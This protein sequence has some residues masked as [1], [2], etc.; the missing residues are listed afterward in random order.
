MLRKLFIASLAATMGLFANAGSKGWNALKSDITFIICNDNGR[1]GYYDQ[2]PIAVTMGE[3]AETVDPESVIALGDVFHYQGVE[4]VNDPLWLSNYESVYTH[5]ELM[6]EWLPIL[7]NH[8]YR[9]NTKAVLD[10]SQI[11]RRWCMPSKY[12]SRSFKDKHTSVKVILLDTAPLIDKYRMDVEDYPDAGKEDMEAQLRWLDNE[13]A[14]ATEEWIVV[15]GHHPIYA[16]TDKNESERSDM[17]DRVDKIL[18][19]HRVDMYICGHIHNFQHIRQSD[20]GID[21]IVNSSASQSRENVNPIDGTVYI[22]G[23]SGFSVLGASADKLT[24]SML[25][26]CGEILHQVVRSK[27]Q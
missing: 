7:G 4:S 25:D 24:L 10:Y 2:K 9:G 26:K 23:K 8:E 20:S 13:L 18:R 17:Q 12:Y 11:S 16:D 22:S 15:V 6:V 1:N 5:P 21:Y 19:K 27:K 3:V 14:I